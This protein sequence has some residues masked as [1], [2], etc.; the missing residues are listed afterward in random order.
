MANAFINSHEFA[1]PAW[2]QLPNFFRKNVY[3][4]PVDP[5]DAPLQAAFA[6]K[7]HFFELMAQQDV[8]EIFHNSMA[9]YRVGRAEFLDILPAQERLVE[10]YSNEDTS[11]KVFFVDVGGGH[12]HELLQF[13]ERFPNLKARMVLQDQEDIIQTAPKTDNM[14]L[15]EQIHRNGAAR[16]T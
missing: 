3:K 2:N 13:R 7:K 15:G 8:L 1:T 11:D 9:S 16:T 5:L 12:G 6:S 14:E 4:N 10:G